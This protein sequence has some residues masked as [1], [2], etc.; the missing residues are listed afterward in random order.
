MAATKTT[1]EGILKEFYLPGVR[2]QLN[3]EV[4]LLSQIESGSEN[5]E[6]KE[7]VLSLHVR[8]TG[9]IG[10][11]AEMGALPTPG[12]QGT[13]KQRVPM[14][15]HYATIQVS[16]PS[17]KATASDA[18]AFARLP[19]L[20]L[21]GAVTDLKRDYNRQLYGTSNGVIATCHT[22]NSSTTVVLL[23]PTR[24]QLDQLTE[25][26]VIDIGTVAA[27][28]TVVE[29]RTINSVD[30]A[31]GTITISGGTISTTTGTHFIFRSGNGGAI[32][33]AGQKEVTGLRSIINS[34]D[35]VHGVSGGTYGAWNSYVD[36]NS[37][38]LRAVS[39]NLFIRASHEVG[40]RSGKNVNLWVTSDGVHR[41]LS[42]QLQSIKRFPNTNVLSGG[43]EA[44]D[45]SSASQGSMSGEKVSLRW[46][47]DCPNFT[48][49]G[50]NTNHLKEHKS[51]DWDWMDEDGSVLARSITTSGGRVDAYDAT[52]FKYS[53][54][55]TDQ[56]NA[57]CRINDISEG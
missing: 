16:G 52:L 3:N 21:E 57:H 13:V 27:P 12:N 33:G 6:G 40:R 5:V 4:F 45:M 46:D 14:Y 37:G 23:N 34:G 7:A 48:A 31:N 56:R 15:Q 18:G 26:M 54:L 24:V 17:M 51:S 43:Y 49:F 53:E 41:Q 47:V 29:A 36:D 22:T 55:A 25:G 9:A 38:V 50:L 8:R 1:M 19:A 44:L 30:Y 20:E 28:T 35:S 39:E 42:N 10:S 11:R 2:S 32:G